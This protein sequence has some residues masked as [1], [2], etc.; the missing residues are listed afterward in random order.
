MK[1]AKPWAAQSKEPK[2][3]T[4]IPDARLDHTLGYEVARAMDTTPRRG[5][6]IQPISRDR[7]NSN[8]RD[9]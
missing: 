6:I 7:W 9:P 4:D 8:N 5:E 2:P 1:H 3:A